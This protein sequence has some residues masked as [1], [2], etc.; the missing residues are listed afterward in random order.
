MN[1][2]L[3][4]RKATALALALTRRSAGSW[5]RLTRTWQSERVARHTGGVTNRYVGDIRRLQDE[6]ARLERD[7][8]A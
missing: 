7:E 2:G 8:A 3:T 6:V 1:A 5:P 4:A